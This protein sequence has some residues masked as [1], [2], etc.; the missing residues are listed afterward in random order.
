MKQIMQDEIRARLDALKKQ[1]ETGQAEL[2]QVEVRRTYLRDTLLRIEGAVQVLE[3]LLEGRPT[4]Q[5]GAVPSEEH[6]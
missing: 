5:N 2:Q 6:S 4:G 1:L 3:E